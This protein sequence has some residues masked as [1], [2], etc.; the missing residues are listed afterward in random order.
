MNQPHSTGMT[1]PI[2]HYIDD[3]DLVC[4]G[5]YEPIS[6]QPPAGLDLTSTD[7][8]QFS[9]RDGSP[10]CGT[11]DHSLVEPIERDREE[12]AAMVTAV[13]EIGAPE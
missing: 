1:K 2:R 7:V 12:S 8:P 3:N 6:A 5:C 9:H 10:L 4:P 11:T 13:L